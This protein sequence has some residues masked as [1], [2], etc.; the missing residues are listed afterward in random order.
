MNLFSGFLHKSQQLR[1]AVGKSSRQGWRK[2]FV[3]VS[4][5]S[6]SRRCNNTPAVVGDQ[7][8]RTIILTTISGMP[9]LALQPAAADV[10]RDALREFTRP[11]V[12]AKDAVVILLDAQSTLREIQ[13]IAITSPNSQE[14]IRAR[15]FWPAYAKRLR[16]V[17][18]AA[19]V[20]ARVVI[21]ASDKEETLSEY[22]GGKAEGTGAA[23]AI[24][25]GL[26]RVLTISGRTIRQEAQDAPD[27]A[28]GA[29]RAIDNFLRQ[30]PPLLLAEAKQFRL[31]RAKATGMQ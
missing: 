10:L 11:D 25:Q 22:Y 8:R 9:M 6:S 21:G 20:V 12:S 30:V 14:R 15:A 2:A 17:A 26:G 16:A 18:E 19:P 3:N 24:Y 23:D 27:A 29:E 13:G 31:E 4:A 7:I 5:S 1:K 28:A